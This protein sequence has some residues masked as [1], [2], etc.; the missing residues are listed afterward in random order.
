MKRSREIKRN[1]SSRQSYFPE[2]SLRPEKRSEIRFVATLTKSGR[3]VC[4]QRVGGDLR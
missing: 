2:R 4:L 3:F 1:I